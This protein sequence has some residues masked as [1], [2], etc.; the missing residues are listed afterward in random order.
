MGTGL[1]TGSVRTVLLFNILHSIEN[2]RL[3]DEA[4][5]ILQRS[6][7]AYILHWR[8]DIPTPRGPSRESRPDLQTIL[9]EISGMDLIY[10]G[11]SRI[12]EPYHWGMQLIKG[13]EDA[14]RNST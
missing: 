6:G 13:G 14:H 1:P 3:L 9:D 5:R 11:N 2:R 12:I 4:E 7:S 8:K 10:R